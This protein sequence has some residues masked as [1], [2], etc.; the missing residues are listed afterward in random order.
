MLQLA[1]ECNG[2]E[3]L[4]LELENIPQI[5]FSRRVSQKFQV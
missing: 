4:G 1:D 3:M 2:N 5:D